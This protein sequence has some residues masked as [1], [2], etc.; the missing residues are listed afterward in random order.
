MKNG[1]DRVAG[2]PWLPGIG[3]EVDRVRVAEAPARLAEDDDV[4]G[5]GTEA[6]PAR[7]SGVA[8]STPGWSL[9][10]ARIRSIAS[11]RCAAGPVQ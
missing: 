4:A 8:A 3:L 10:I 5:L 1:I 11:D 6:E 2:W 9:A 7:R